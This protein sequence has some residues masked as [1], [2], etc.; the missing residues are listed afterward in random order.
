VP[1]YVQSLLSYLRFAQKRHQI[2]HIRKKNIEVA[3]ASASDWPFKALMQQLHRVAVSLSGTIESN[4][5]AAAAFDAGAVDASRS[6]DILVLDLL[7]EVRPVRC[8]CTTTLMR[9]FHFR[10]VLHVL[11]AIAASHSVKFSN[12]IL[13][14]TIFLS[15]SFSLSLPGLGPIYLCLLRSYQMLNTFFIGKGGRPCWCRQP[16]RSLAVIHLSSVGNAVSV[17]DTRFP[18][19][20]FA[21]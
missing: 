13:C 4:L 14:L 6:F 16:V 17:S 8:I 15:V 7:S 21:S 10:Q 18:I 11:V 9:A 3:T 5:G 20:T 19:P 12:A 2:Q 1:A